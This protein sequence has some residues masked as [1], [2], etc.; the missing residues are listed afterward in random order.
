MAACSF[1]KT[2]SGLNGTGASPKLLFRSPEYEGKSDRGRCGD[3]LE[4]ID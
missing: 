4:E 2:W 3:V 1:C